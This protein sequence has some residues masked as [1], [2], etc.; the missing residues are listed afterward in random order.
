MSGRNGKHLSHI[1]G[2]ACVLV[3]VTAANGH[4]YKS[5]PPEVVKSLRF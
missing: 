5:Q 2:G 3:F 4:K 1:L